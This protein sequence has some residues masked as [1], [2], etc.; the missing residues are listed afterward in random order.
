MYQRKTLREIRYIG[1]KSYEYLWIYIV[2][3]ILLP[4][5][6]ITQNMYILLAS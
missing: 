3:N 4:L 6:M 2:R 5:L 1:D